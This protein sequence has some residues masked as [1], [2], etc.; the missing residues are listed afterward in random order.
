MW[1]WTYYIAPAFLLAVLFGAWRVRNTMPFLW[2]GVLFYLANVFLSLPW[3]TFGSFEL[4][5]DRYNYLASLGLFFILASLPAYFAVKKPTWKGPTQVLLVILAVFW[6]FGAFARIPAWKNTTTLIENAM[7]AQGDNFGKAY[8]WRGMI[9]ADDGKA[10]DAL[11]DFNKAIERNP[12]LV[13][14]YKYRGNIMGLRKNYSQSVADL[15][16][17]IEHFP[18]AAP[19]IYNRGLSYVNLGNDSL[20]MLDFTRCLQI[21]ESFVRAYRARGNTYLKLG[22]TEKGQ[23]DLKRYE[24]MKPQ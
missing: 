24:E 21:D 16:K 1:H 9:L 13:E 3:A 19:E 5:S 18:E 22:E 10:D 8:L 14:V 12:L 7:K 15:T 2:F 11:K 23:A 20:A 4:R 6:L 17:Y